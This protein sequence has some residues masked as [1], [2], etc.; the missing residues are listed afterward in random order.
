M[1]AE[2]VIPPATLELVRSTWETARE[3]LEETASSAPSAVDAG[4]LTAMLTSMLSRVVA[5]SATVSDS[6]SAAS[7]QVGETGAAFWEL[8]A[9][10]AAGYS[11]P[12]RGL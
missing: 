3:S 11:G 12:R 2:L 4:E 9:D 8:D 7:A 10:V 6:L 1:G 5:S